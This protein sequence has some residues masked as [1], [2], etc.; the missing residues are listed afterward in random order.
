MC[1][2]FIEKYQ[3]HVYNI[4]EDTIRITIANPKCVK[5][6]KGNKDNTKD[7][8]WIGE[9]FR[10]VLVTGNYITKNKIFQKNY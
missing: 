2:E 4:L 5:A 9:L 1:M 6:V 10:I 3:V 7:S 8:K